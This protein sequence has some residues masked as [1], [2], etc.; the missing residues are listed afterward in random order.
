MQ[1]KSKRAKPEEWAKY[2]SA[3]LVMKI[4]RNK[5]PTYLLGTLRET[6][7]TERRKPLNGKF[8]NNSKGKIGKQ[9]IQNRIGFMNGIKDEWMMGN[10]SDNEIRQLLKKNLFTFDKEILS[11]T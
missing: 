6:I 1:K 10:I 7:F 11:S 3:T 5:S 4:I 9:R 8:Y 2:A